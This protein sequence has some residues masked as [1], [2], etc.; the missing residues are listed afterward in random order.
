MPCISSDQEATGKWPVFCIALS[1]HI[2]TT[3]L[4]QVLKQEVVGHHRRNTMHCFHVLWAFCFVHI[5]LDIFY[6]IRV[7]LACFDFSLL[8]FFFFV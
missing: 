8:I 2:A 1:L 4:R 5:V 6:F 7:L 3:L